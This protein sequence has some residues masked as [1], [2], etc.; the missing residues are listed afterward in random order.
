MLLFATNYQYYKTK[1][2]DYNVRYYCMMLLITFILHQC[3]EN[4]ASHSTKC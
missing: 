3:L 4:D 2:S 1:I